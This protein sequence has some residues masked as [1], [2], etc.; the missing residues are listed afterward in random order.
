MTTNFLAGWVRGQG[1]NPP[2]GKDPETYVND[3]RHAGVILAYYGERMIPLKSVKVYSV[4]S[5]AHPA[6]VTR[7]TDQYWVSTAER[8]EAKAVEGWS[9]WKV[10]SAPG[11]PERQVSVEG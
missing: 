7:V 6:L 10:L 9:E 11:N 2:S 8:F 5:G 3:E 4:F 1:F